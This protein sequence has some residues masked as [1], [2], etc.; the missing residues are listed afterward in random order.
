[1][2]GEFINFHGP[3]EA[4][5]GGRH[6]QAHHDHENTDAG[7]TW[8]IVGR[9]GNDNCNAEQE[10]SQN[11]EIAFAVQGRA[12]GADVVNKRSFFLSDQGQQ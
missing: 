1:M 6:Q 7:N 10:H 9:A 2:D 5:I 3:H 8:T 12:V 4:G 11:D